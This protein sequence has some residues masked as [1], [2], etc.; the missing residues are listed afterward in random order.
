MDE[1]PIYN[2]RTTYHILQRTQINTPRAYIVCCGG[3]N[4]D[5]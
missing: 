2:F 3:S 4:D 5:W 1:T